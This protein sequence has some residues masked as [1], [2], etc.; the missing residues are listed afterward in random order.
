M[1]TFKT[2]INKIANNKGKVI[3]ANDYSN[4]TRNLEAKTIKNIK[5]IPLWNKIQFSFIV[6]IRI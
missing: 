2:R 4:S 6:A 5:Q 1:A 3:L